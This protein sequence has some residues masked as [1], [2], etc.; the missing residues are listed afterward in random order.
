MSCDITTGFGDLCK[1][2]LGGNSSIYVFNSVDDPFTLVA[3]AATAI[4]PLITVVYEYAIIG[5]L[6]TFGQSMPP[7]RNTLSTV[8][9]QTLVVTIGKQDATKAAELNLLAKGFPMCV[10]KD[11]EGNYHAMG[12]DDGIDFTVDATTGGA[13]ADGNLYTLTGVST[14]G[15]LAPILD[16]ATEAALLALLP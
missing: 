2:S 4:N 1:D 10:V 14:T 9:T 13:K 15:A 8:N 12:I 11:R 6:N 16:S 3:S 7:D 5:D